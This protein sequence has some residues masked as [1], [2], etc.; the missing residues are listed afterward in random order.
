MTRCAAGVE[1]QYQH[2]YQCQDQCQDQCQCQCLCQSVWH[3]RE[4]GP[5]LHYGTP[6]IIEGPRYAF[7]KDPPRP[8]LPP[9][10]TS[11]LPCAQIKGSGRAEG[12]LSD[13][14]ALELRSGWSTRELTAVSAN[15]WLSGAEN[16]LP[17]QEVRAAR[18][19]RP[20]HYPAAARLSCPSLG[21]EAPPSGLP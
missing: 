2:Q 19:S 11:A 7:G 6:W 1:R 5:A 13:V 16:T 21:S 17:S 8:S 12:S 20:R 4:R 14:D 9:L 10:L 3:A 15:A 18:P